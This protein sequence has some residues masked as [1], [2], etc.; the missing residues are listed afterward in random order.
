MRDLIIR[1]GEN[2]YPIEIENRLVEHPAISQA[3]VVGVAHHQLG[4]EVAA[5]VVV[6]EG[7]TL[8]ID[9]VKSWVGEALA[10]YK[11]PTYG[12][13]R[14]EVPYN[15]TGKVLKNKVEEDV[16]ASLGATST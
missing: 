12:V 5:V 6:H 15:A 1:G 13:L 11:V 10:G 16:S 4:Q 9:T 7:E 2:I 3:C 8:E 14:T